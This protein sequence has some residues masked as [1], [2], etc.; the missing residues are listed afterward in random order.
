LRRFR[1]ERDERRG[2][3]SIVARYVQVFL[4]EILAGMA[5]ADLMVREAAMMTGGLLCLFSR[6]KEFSANLE[7]A[8]PL[9]PEE[10]P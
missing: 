2:G 7:L 1:A 5:K 10:S 3:A 8:I 9:L 4:T 6:E